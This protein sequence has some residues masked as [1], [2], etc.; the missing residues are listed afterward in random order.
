MGL[1]L[2]PTVR[3]LLIYVPTYY[4]FIHTTFRLSTCPPQAFMDK[5][6]SRVV[7]GSQN[8][9]KPQYPEYCNQPRH[10]IRGLSNIRARRGMIS[11][12]VYDCYLLR[13]RGMGKKILVVKFPTT[14]DS[15]AVTGTLYPRINK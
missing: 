1:Y 12:M 10:S 6:K 7:E 9:G 2:Q 5:N 15:Q 8:L 13:N 3:H 14:S 11:R 4:L